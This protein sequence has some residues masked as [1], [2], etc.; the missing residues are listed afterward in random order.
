MSVMKCSSAMEVDTVRSEHQ[1]E[2]EYVLLDLGSV[3]SQLHIPPKAPYVLSVSFFRFKFL[4]F[5]FRYL[6]FQNANCL[7]CHF[8]IE[9]S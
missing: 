6:I 9:L 8:T 1:D 5:H 7:Y 4:F 3:S 2:E